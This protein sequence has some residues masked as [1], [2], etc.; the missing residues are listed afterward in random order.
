MWSVKSQTNV[1]VLY[2]HEHIF[3]LKCNY[4]KGS[5]DMTKEKKEN[6]A[7]V[8]LFYSIIILAVIVLNAR[9]EYLNKVHNSENVEQLYIQH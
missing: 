1:Y 6:L 2:W 5:V 7:G 4:G 3:V 9:C 8:I